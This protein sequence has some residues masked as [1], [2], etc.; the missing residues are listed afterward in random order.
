[1]VAVTIGITFRASLSKSVNQRSKQRHTP[2]TPFRF[3][4]TTQVHSIYTGDCGQ[5]GF[6]PEAPLDSFLANPRDHFSHLITYVT[7]TIESKK[8]STP[9]GG[10]IHRRQHG[11]GQG[12]RK[13]EMRIE[14]KRGKEGRGK[15]KREGRG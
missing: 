7:S 15:R 8:L 10:K 9:A 6:C 12:V 11:E 2:R 1:M 4:V 13:R 14:R 5:L 3:H